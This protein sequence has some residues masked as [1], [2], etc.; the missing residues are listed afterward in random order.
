VCG[1]FFFVIYGPCFGIVCGLGLVGNALSF[2][3]LHRYSRDNV[4]TYLLKSLALADN[5]LL[6]TGGTVQIGMGMALYFGYRA[7]LAAI[8]PYVQTYAWPAVQITQ[9]L[10]VWMTVLVAANRYVAVCRPLH[11]PRLCTK[12]RVRIQIAAMVVLVVLTSTPRFFEHVVDVRAV[13]AT[14]GPCD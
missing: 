1:A 6:L 12:R 7:Q 8:Y 2:A 10:S 4:A 11:A 14:R 3:V 5:L 13:S 9:L